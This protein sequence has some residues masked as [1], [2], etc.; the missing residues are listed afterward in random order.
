MPPSPQAP[1]RNRFSTRVLGG[2]TEPD[3]RFTLTNERTVLAW[4]R[5]SLAFLASGIAVEAFT[6]DLFPEPM[7]TFLAVVLLLLGVL[8]SGGAALRWVGVER[9]LRQKTPLPL[10]LIAPLLGIGGAIAS[11][12][13]VVF[14]LQT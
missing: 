8:I 2:G 4:I 13:M 7:R 9:S 3:P 11:G 14:V 12:A 5:T 6:E 1:P 10:P